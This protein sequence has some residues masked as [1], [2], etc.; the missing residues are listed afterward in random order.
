MLERTRLVWIGAL[1]GWAGLACSGRGLLPNQ[2]DAAGA[3][4]AGGST[5]VGGAANGGRAMAG[6]GGVAVR[7]G[8]GGFSG[9]GGFGGFGGAAGVG[10]AGAPGG[11][12]GAAG[13]V[14]RDDGGSDDSVDTAPVDGGSD[15]H[16]D[17]ALVDGGSDGPTCTSVSSGAD[18]GCSPAAS[19]GSCEAG[20]AC[21]PANPCR[22]G[23]VSCE[24]GP[25]RCVE[26]GNQP[27]GTRCGTNLFCMN[28]SCAVDNCQGSCTPPTPCHRGV[29][30]CTTGTVLCMDTGTLVPDGMSCGPSRV[31]R[32]G[33]C[34]GCSDLDAGCAS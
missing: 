25:G 24:T 11:A 18:C 30:S 28:G 4:G 3:S 27:N 20:T 7:A 10:G 17:A 12:G 16:L 22:T 13:A 19:C 5:G 15:G 32:S 1:L 34:V 9:F 21:M 33:S 8:A 29:I 31:C 14:T 6:G 2:P 26:S 23:V